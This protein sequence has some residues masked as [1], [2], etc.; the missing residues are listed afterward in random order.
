MDGSSVVMLLVGA[1]FLW[2]G[3]AV[4]VLNYVRHSR[5]DTRA[6]EHD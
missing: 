1:T 4:S 3:V 2:G 6:F 5:R